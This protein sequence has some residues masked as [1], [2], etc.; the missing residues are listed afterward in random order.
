MRRRKCI[1]RVAVSTV[2]LWLCV[3]GVGAGQRRIP[4]A[5]SAQPFKRLPGSI[6]RHVEALGR[7]AARRA[8]S[9]LSMPAS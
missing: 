3:S 9:R 5:P 2:V 7:R 1:G 6:E 8:R 4:S